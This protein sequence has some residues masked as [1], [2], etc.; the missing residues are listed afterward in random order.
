[1]QLHRDSNIPHAD[2]QNQV[3]DCKWYIGLVTSSVIR[4]KC[5]AD[6][7]NF[8]NS[9]RPLESEGPI[10]KRARKKISHN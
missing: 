3:E 7:F 2:T 5:T 9:F 6:P 4:K 8:V 10:K 1:M